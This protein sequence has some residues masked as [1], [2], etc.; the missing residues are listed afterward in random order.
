MTLL[1]LELSDAGILVAGSERDGLLNVDGDSVA[2]PGFALP[3]KNR[4]TV[5]RAAEMKAHLYP[6]QILNDFWDQLNT[7][8][9]EQPSRFAQNHAEIAF[10]H[11]AR[12][13]ET[14]KHHGQE[15]VIAV[16]GFYTREHLGFILGITRELSI[17]VRGFVP[18]AVA[19]V[20]DRLPEGL[21]LHLD[22]HLHRFE[23]TRLQRA[24]QL[25]QKDTVSLE[26]NGLSKLYSRWVDAIA[27]EFVRTTRFDPLHQAATEQ[28][29][30]DRLPGVLSQLKQN[31]SVHFEMTGGSKV[32]H[33][34]I[35]RD[36][37]YKKSAPVFQEFQ[38]LI[39]RL[40]NR[41]R[42]NELGAVLMLTDRMARLPGI[43]HMLAGIEN[44]K[45]I[46]LAP[47]SGAQGLFRF[48]NQLTASPPEGSAP[49]LTTRP[50]PAEGPISNTVPDRHAQT[51]QRP[52]HILYR[53][54]AYRI[55]EKP[56]IIGLERAADGFG[57]QIQGQIAGVSR[58]H[59][60]VQLRGDEVVLNDYSSYGT[61]VN[62]EPVHMKIILSLGQVI[63][64]G[65]PGERLKLIACMEPS[66]GE[67]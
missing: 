7:E 24:G 62:D 58:K 34:T 1:G 53:D 2:S 63:R 9:L 66:Y 27:E 43:T 54:L 55:T 6:R 33:V 49:F 48:E 50:L 29:L 32:Y 51:H 57:I 8:P 19:A 30:Y 40:Y 23:I 12:I 4:L 59:C 31:P 16:P 60:S 45:I 61:F 44:Y 65:T 20:P 41:Y 3:E 46:E 35:T 11:L 18:L 22:I 13:W 52:T 5:G 21:L 47:G 64:V 42:D 25:S 14:V 26:G 38:R 15:M 67:T 37:F 17:P 36:L 56:L 10:E 39:G 28:E